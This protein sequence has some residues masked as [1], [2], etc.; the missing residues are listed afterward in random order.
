MLNLSIPSLRLELHLVECAWREERELFSIRR[1][2]RELV[3]LCEAAERATDFEE[4]DVRRAAHEAFLSAIAVIHL[5]DTAGAKL[6]GHAHIRARTVL[7]KLLDALAPHVG[8]ADRAVRRVVVD[9]LEIEEALAR[10][11]D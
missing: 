5:V 2:M 1:Q 10:A 4:R 3:E 8:R 6:P 7:A 11:I 9:G